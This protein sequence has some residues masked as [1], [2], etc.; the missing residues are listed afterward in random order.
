MRL[1]GYGHRERLSILTSCRTGFPVYMFALNSLQSW[2]FLTLKEMFLWI[3]F[4]LQAYPIFMSDMW[5]IVV[6][7]EG[8]HFP[9]T[10]ALCAL[11]TGLACG[12]HV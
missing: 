10:L 9:V 8:F 1:R 5:P 3:F 7:K 12:M 11:F 4:S 2:L 6:K